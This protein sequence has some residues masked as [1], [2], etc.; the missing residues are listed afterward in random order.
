[1]V[2]RKTDKQT[3]RDRQRRETDRQR[4]RE[5]GRERQRQAGRQ[6]DRNREKGTETETRMFHV[7][8]SHFLFCRTFQKR[9]C[10]QQLQD[11]EDNNNKKTTSSP[12]PS[13]RPPST[14]ELHQPPR[15]PS[16]DA[17]TWISPWRNPLL[18][19][20]R[21]FPRTSASRNPEYPP[22][23]RNRTHTRTLLLEGLQ[24][25]GCESRP[26]HEHS[27]IRGQDRQQISI[28]G[29]TWIW[30]PGRLRIRTSGRWL[31]RKP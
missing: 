25:P 17:Q 3:D 8:L 10:L 6:K 4:K 31:T 30:N 9:W 26:S 16:G 21:T 12:P 7:Y 15:L 22:R 23:T 1:M 24:P 18:N 2:G 14:S 11:P 27:R 13:V 5:Q 28:P 19:L 20:L 29:R